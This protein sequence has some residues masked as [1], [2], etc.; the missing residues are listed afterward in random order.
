MDINNQTVIITGA[1]S[2][3]GAACARF[4]AA[5]GAKL[6]LWDRNIEGA[7]NLA[8][9]LG[10]LAIVCDVTDAASVA[11]A[12]QE[13]IAKSGSPRVLINC[14]GILIGSRILGREGP[15]D[16]DHFQKTLSVNVMGTFNTLRLV[17]EAMSKSEPVS[18]DGARG[19]IINTASV[20]AYEGQIG[21]AAYSA[22][23]GAIVSMTLPAAR[24][25]G[26]F[27]IRVMT[28]APGAAETPMI[29]GVPDDIRKNIEA[30]IP[31]PSR[32]VKPEEF[33]KLAFHITDNDMLNGEVIRLDGAAR[34]AA[35]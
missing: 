15:A 13:T 24:E 7:Q 34:L 17:A 32:F 31:F 19:V 30:G 1:G 27:G 4:F 23:K 25:L 20:A 28:I 9:E 5:K 3:L 2:G 35:K 10:G 26:K 11:T 18:E 6:S 33:S 21:Q 14:A 12:L 22:S 8:R 16:L 29:H